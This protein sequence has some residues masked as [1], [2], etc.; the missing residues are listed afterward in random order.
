MVI[1]ELIEKLKVLDPELRVF[2]R[3]YEGGFNDATC[4]TTIYNFELDCNKE[5]YYGS[6]EIIDE[7]NSNK[8][9]VKGIVL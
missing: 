5:W 3:G 9:T 4:I 7:E 8:Q 2:V 6:H 1:K